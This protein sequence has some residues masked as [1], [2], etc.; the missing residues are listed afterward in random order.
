MSPFPGIWFSVLEDLP[1]WYEFGIFSKKKFVCMNHFENMTIVSF[2][3]FIFGDLLP[4][5]YT[6]YIE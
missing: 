5:F 6:I 3:D 4:L 1:V 2:C